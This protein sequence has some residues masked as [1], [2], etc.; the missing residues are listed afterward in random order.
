VLKDKLPYDFI[1]DI[2]P[3]AGVYRQPLVM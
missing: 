2:A 3:V 1:R